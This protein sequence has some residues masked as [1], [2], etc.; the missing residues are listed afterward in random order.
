MYQP[1]DAG[2]A[3]YFLSMLADGDRNAKYAAAIA[4]CVADFKKQQKRPPVVLDLGCGTGLLTRLALDAGA[5][6]V[7]GVD[8]NRTMVQLARRALE[9]AGKT[10][11]YELF[12][13]TVDD[14]AATLKTPPVF[15]VIVS[16]ILGTLHT[17]ENMPEYVGAASKYLRTFA[18]GAAYVVPARATTFVRPFVVADDPKLPAPANAY[19]REVLASVARA[20]AWTPT[21]ELGVLLL[22]G[23]AGPAVAVRT[24]SFSKL[25]FEKALPLKK[26]QPLTWPAA[27]GVR[28]AVLEFEC[29]LWNG[30]RIDNTISE[31]KRILAD[32]GAAEACGRYDAWGFFV[33]GVDDAA[34]T[35]SL[36]AY[37]AAGLPTLAFGRHVVRGEVNEP[38]ARHATELRALADWSDPPPIGGRWLCDRDAPRALAMRARGDDVVLYEPDALLRALAMRVDPELPAFSTSR[39]LAAASG[40]PRSGVSVAD[41]VLA[42]EVLLDRST[43][44]ARRASGVLV[45]EPTVWPRVKRSVSRKAY[46]FG[47]HASKW[48][49]AAPEAILVGMEAT[50]PQYDGRRGPPPML[51][52]DAGVG[53]AH[54]SLDLLDDVAEPGAPGTR[55]F[56]EVRAT[57]AGVKRDDAAARHARCQAFGP[58]ALDVTQLVG[59][60]TWTASPDAKRNGGVRVS[61]DGDGLAFDSARRAWLGGPELDDENDAPRAKKVKVTP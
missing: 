47:A 28:L 42:E 2:F 37:S 18:G 9:A 27:A 49:A 7:V 38:S 60:A 26:T 17:S 23:E 19:R 4:Q 30:H 6:K 31:L 52:T 43:S 51:R 1:A 45:D 36:R 16:E 20:P 34:P 55:I 40:E 8:T 54:W 29:E 57:R 15:D 5:K 50:V 56:L 13:G 10:E 59:E 11:G 22:D 41:A 3:T 35:A 58:H 14:Y 46:A 21:N 12:N 33:A 25:P 32:R 44:A 48:S 53:G 39:S 61:H 24:D